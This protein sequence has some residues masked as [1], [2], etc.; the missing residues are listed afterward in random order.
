MAEKQDHG[1]VPDGGR[2]LSLYA[3]II[4]NHQSHIIL[5]ENIMISWEDIIINQ[6]SD[7][8]TGLYMMKCPDIN[9]GYGRLARDGGI[10]ED[11]LTD[12]DGQYLEFQAGRMFNQYGGTSA[13]K[14]PISQTPFTP[15]LTDRWTEIWFPVKEIGGL[16]DVSPMG[17][18]NIEAE[19]GKLQIGINALA[20]AQGKVIVKSEGKVVFTEEKNFKPMDVYKTSVALKYKC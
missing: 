18:M 20:F 15:G 5:S 1:R 2:D 14:T 3:K 17:V 11:L 7:L 4:L 6:V 10:W 16:T 13:F 19:N 12:T 8:V 9:S